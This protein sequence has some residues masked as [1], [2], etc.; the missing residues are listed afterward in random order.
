MARAAAETAVLRHAA[1]DSLALAREEGRQER[2]KL[3]ACTRALEGTAGQHA[4][5]L[6]QLRHV[7]AGLLTHAEKHERGARSCEAR[8]RDA[9]AALARQDEELA[10]LSARVL[11]AEEAAARPPPPLAHPNTACTAR[12]L[13]VHTTRA[14]DY[15]AVQSAV[16]RE[17][18]CWHDRHCRSTP[19]PPSRQTPPPRQAIAAL[20]AEAPKALRAVAALEGSLLGTLTPPPCPPHPRRFA[21]KLGELDARTREQVEGLARGVRQMRAELAQAVRVCEALVALRSCPPVEHATLKAKLSAPARPHAT[22]RHSLARAGGRA[23]RWFTC[24]RERAERG[25]GLVEQLEHEFQTRPRLCGLAEQAA[26]L[27]A[28][29]PLENTSSRSHSN[30]NHASA[31]AGGGQAVGAP[32]HRPRAIRQTGRPAR[33]ARRRPAQRRRAG[34][35]WLRR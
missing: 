1:K 29:R 10:L 19:A 14:C 11:R 8:L 3:L 16:G 31:D 9:L 22:L 15:F 32:R 17:S 12:E 2:D 30:T 4:E 5:A 18:L 23:Q 6:E 26:A 25:R 33:P 20:A 21:G 7:A 34:R 35:R 28:G 24:G 27:L 13:E